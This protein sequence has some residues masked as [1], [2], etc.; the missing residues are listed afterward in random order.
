MKSFTF[1]RVVEDRE[2]WNFPK[3]RRYDVGTFRVEEIEFDDT[4]SMLKE[5]THWCD[6]SIDK[7]LFTDEK[8]A[9]LAAFKYSFEKLHKVSNQLETLVEEDKLWNAD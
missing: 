2:Y 5:F 9:N 6:E 4:F 7:Y 8:S 3:N 1:Y